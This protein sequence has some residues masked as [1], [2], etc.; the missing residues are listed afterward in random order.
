MTAGQFDC[1]RLGND[2]DNF[3]GSISAS[4]CQ[5]QI[6]VG[7]VQVHDCI[8]VDLDVGI[9]LGLD[10]PVCGGGVEQPY[11]ALFIANDSDWGIMTAGK[12]KGNGVAL[13]RI[14]CTLMNVMT[15]AVV[16]RSECSVVIGGKAEILFARMRRKSMFSVK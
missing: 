15:F 8:F 7:Y 10:R 6:I 11:K 5:S 14:C 3:A 16:G 4:C 13:A 1:Y 9:N 2:V 12:A